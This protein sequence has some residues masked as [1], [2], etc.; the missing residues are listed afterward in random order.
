MHPGFVIRFPTTEEAKSG[1]PL[2]AF[3]ILI[4][5]VVAML[6]RK[7][8]GQLHLWYGVMGVMAFVLLSIA[9]KFS[10]FGSRYHLPFFI[11]LAP[12][13]S[14]VFERAIP[15]TPFILLTILVAV[16]SWNWLVGIQERPLIPGNAGGVSILDQSRE[17]M[18][19]TLSPGLYKVSQDLV[20]RTQEEDCRTVAL[21]LKG[22]AAE[23]PFWVLMGAPR[24][25]L[26]VEWIVSGTP[27]ARF[28]PPDFQ[29]CAVICDDSCPAEWQEVRGLP[30]VHERADFRLYL[31]NN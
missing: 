17:E 10:V 5:F 23:Y 14:V 31:R 4:T 1:N 6:R 22:A 25:D 20:H 26:H 11:L 19:F 18:Y 15:R 27:S 29:P 21:V 9:F 16:A 24:E 2:Q 30:L 3:L 12:L 13:V 28:I 7:D 8:I